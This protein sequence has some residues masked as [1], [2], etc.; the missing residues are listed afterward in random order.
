MT[1]AK[2]I[3]LYPTKIYRHF[4]HDSLYRNSIFLLSSTTVM[5]TFGFLFWTISAHFYPSNQ[6]GLAT[7]TVSAITLLG[8]FAILGYDS[9]IIRYLFSSVRKASLLS[10]ILVFSGSIGLILGI[11]YLVLLPHISPKLLYLRTNPVTLVMFLILIPL[12]T[13]NVLIDSANIA[14]RSAHL[15][16]I[17]NLVL[18]LIKVGLLLVVV[19]YGT[20]GIVGSYFAG[21]FVAVVIGTLLLVGRKY[22]RH[23]PHIS[24]KEIRYTLNFSLLNHTGSF[25]STIPALALPLIILNYLGGSS[26]AYFYISFAVASLLFTI[27]FVAADVL[28]AE[29]SVNHVPINKLIKKAISMIGVFLVPTVVLII[30]LAPKILS[31]FGQDYATHGT[32]IMRLLV[33]SSIPLSICYLSATLFNLSRR[34]KEFIFV[35]FVATAS[36]IS[37]SIL[38]LKLGHGL[39]GVGVAWLVSQCLAAIL[40]VVLGYNKPFRSKGLRVKGI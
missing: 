29:G 20:R 27:P 31:I 34:L 12:F 24:V 36:N 9:S 28:F 39:T 16:L 40:Y 19:T 7:A 26:A 35:N 5:A 6:V 8:S 2:Q 21:Y 13:F 1:R 4:M 38:S 11:G 17:K 18:S 33:I 3:Q 14:L 15:S 37:L 10:S 25:L 22:K 30:A 23:K 32:D